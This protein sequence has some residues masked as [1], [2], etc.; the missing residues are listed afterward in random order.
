MKIWVYLSKIYIHL[1]FALPHILSLFPGIEYVFDRTRE[2]YLDFHVSG[3]LDDKT[4]C[5]DKYQKIRRQFRKGASG[6]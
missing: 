2:H 1:G 5:Q 3:A 4:I 6:L